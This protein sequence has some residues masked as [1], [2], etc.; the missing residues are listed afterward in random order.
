MDD[1]RTRRQLVAQGMTVYA[2]AAAVRRGDLVRVRRG[3]YATPGLD[4][5]TIRAVRVGGRLACVSELRARGVWVLDDARIHVHVAANASR[6]RDPDELRRRDPSD[7][8][9]VHWKPLLNPGAASDSHVGALDALIQAAGCLDAFALVASLDSA[10]R[11]GVVR[12]REL[13]AAE[14]P[15]AMR[16]AVGYLDPQAESGLESMVRELARLVGLRTS[17]QVSFAG[18]GRVDLVVEDRIIVETDGAAFHDAEVTAR[19]R[20]RDALLVGRGCTVLHFRYAQV[21]FDRP[22]VVRTII[23]AVEAHRGVHN[24]GSIARRARRRSE[25]LGLA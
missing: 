7:D 17:S 21:I 20:R 19:D 24:S 2:I 12:M 11:L 9:I 18:I 3:H 22:L 1:S 13:Q 23:A 15:A 16:S 25:K 8:C 14:L 4:T 5:S 6:L 10:V